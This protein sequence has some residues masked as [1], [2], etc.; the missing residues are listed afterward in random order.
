MKN[1]KKSVLSSVLAASMLI[2]V[3]AF[4]A[5]SDDS[6]HG[7]FEKKQRN[8]KRS[9]LVHVQKKNFLGDTHLE[10]Y[11]RLLAE[12]YSPDSVEDWERA[13]EERKNVTEEWQTLAQDMKEQRNSEASSSARA[14]WK[15]KLENGEMTREEWKKYLQERNEKRE[16]MAETRRETLRKS[17]ESNKPWM[18]A[19][20]E[21][22]ES[23][24]EEKIQAQ[25]AQLLEQYEQTT[26]NMKERL[27]E[28][29]ASI[30]E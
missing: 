8:S 15:E 30:T 19:L 12:K 18:K 4:A 27:E 13:I 21:A 22:I 9:K 25:L 2:P 26:A 7:S 3:S 23:E 10:T 24:D 20:A 16:E 1:W 28:R 11:I 6:L 5:E 14:E 17:I 29:T